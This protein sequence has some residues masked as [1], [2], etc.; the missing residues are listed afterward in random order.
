MLQF[1]ANRTNSNRS[2]NFLIKLKLCCMRVFQACRNLMLPPSGG[3]LSNQMT[4][5]GFQC[6]VETPHLFLIAYE[7]VANLLL[8]R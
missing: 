1:N 2:L 3:S 8:Q 6:S 5:T 7:L 4:G